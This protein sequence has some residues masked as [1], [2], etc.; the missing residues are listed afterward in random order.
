MILIAVF[1]AFAATFLF[2]FLV[3]IGSIEKRFI[4]WLQ[5][6]NKHWAELLR[7][8]ELKGTLFLTLYG[9][10]QHFLLKYLGL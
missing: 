9:L 6:E 2:V 10:F 4:Y 8:F 5:E 3:M 7:I 1:V